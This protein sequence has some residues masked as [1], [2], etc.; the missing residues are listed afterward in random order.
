MK[1]YEKEE[2]KELTTRCCFNANADGF[3]IFPSNG[4]HMNAAHKLKYNVHMHGIQCI[5]AHNNSNGPPNIELP[6]TYMQSTPKMRKMM[7]FC[8]NENERNT[9]PPSSTKKQ[10]T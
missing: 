5:R 9:T 4:C 7:P 2:K 3:S 10:L 1:C 6:C 8:Q